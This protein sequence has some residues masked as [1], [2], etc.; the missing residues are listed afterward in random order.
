MEAVKDSTETKREDL[1]TPTIIN[2]ILLKEITSICTL[3]KRHSVFRKQFK[4]KGALGQIPGHT[5]TGKYIF[6]IPLSDARGGTIGLAVP[7]AEVDRYRL[8]ENQEVIITC[9]MVP[10]VY[11]GKLEFNFYCSDIQP[12]CETDTGLLNQDKLLRELLK[13]FR[14]QTVEFPEKKAY[15]IGVICPR[16]AVAYRDFNRQIFG[17]EGVDY[18]P[19]TVNIF[20]KD[21]I[22]HAISTTESDILVVTRGGG[23]EGDFSVFNDNEVVSVW[24]Q[25]TGTYKISALGHS[26]DSTIFDVFSDYSALTPT[27]AGVYVRKKIEEIKQKEEL[28]TLQER[29]VKQ[30]EEVRKKYDQKI[31]KIQKSH[32]TRMILMAGSFVVLIVLWLMFK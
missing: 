28:R 17:L 6:N 21:E 29:F 23:D 19:V 3:H 30:M 5:N 15:K 16:S 1:Y 22:I 10:N 7:A 8:Y 31:E 24:A 27:D 20:S 9:I 32:R 2:D 13:S 11:K 26:T 18:F 12:V 14:K 4:V 25:K